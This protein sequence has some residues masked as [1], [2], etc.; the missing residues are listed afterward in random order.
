MLSQKIPQFIQFLMRR[1]R[2]DGAVEIK[3]D[4]VNLETGKIIDGLNG[5]DGFNID[6][7]K[8]AGHV[9]RSSQ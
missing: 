7:I 8:G 2:Y 9:F 3:L 5:F 6:F 4:I 1:R